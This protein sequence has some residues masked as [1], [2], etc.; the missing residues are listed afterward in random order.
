[1][2]LTEDCFYQ[3]VESFGCDVNSLRLDLLKDGSLLSAMWVIFLRY[4]RAAFADKLASSFKYA[5]QKQFELEYASVNLD[6]ADSGERRLLCETANWMRLLFTMI[7]AR[8]N[9]C[10][11]LH[12][13]PKLIEGFHV[14]YTL[15]T[16]QSKHTSYRADIFEHEGEICRKKR[17]FTCHLKDKRNNVGLSA[18]NDLFALPQAPLSPKPQLQ[19]LPVC[20]VD[21]DEAIN[22]S[23]PAAL[24]TFEMIP[25]AAV[26]SQKKRPCPK[27]SSDFSFILFDSFSKKDYQPSFELKASFEL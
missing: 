22:S 12:I 8:R 4:Y 10:F 9:K 13:V 11:Y 2:R 26:A 24:R 19:V 18:V 15:G 5:S 3:L 20:E 25:I 27:V 17:K 6:K 23:K 7:P 16:G 21:S 1:M 14:K